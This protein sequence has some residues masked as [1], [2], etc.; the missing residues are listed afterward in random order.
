MKLENVSSRH[1]FALIHRY[2]HLCSEVADMVTIESQWLS[3]HPR[4]YDGVTLFWLGSNDRNAGGC[5]DKLGG[6]TI[7]GISLPRLSGSVHAH[8]NCPNTPL[9]RIA[10]KEAQRAAHD[11]CRALGE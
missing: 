8:L 3:D 6:K 10:Y 5:Q 1:I 11:L 9:L 7:M 2:I 4:D